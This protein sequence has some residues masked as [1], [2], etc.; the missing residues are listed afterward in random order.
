M[1]CKDTQKQRFLFSSSQAIVKQLNK[2]QMYQLLQPVY[3]VGIIADT[4]NTEDSEWYYHH[5][6][7]KSGEKKKK[8]RDLLDVLEICEAIKLAEQAADTSH[9][10]ECLRYLLE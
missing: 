6:L 3:G 9:R 7:V 1:K 8:L 4:W 2:G 5:R 10:V